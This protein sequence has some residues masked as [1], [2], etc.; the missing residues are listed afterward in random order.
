MKTNKEKYDSYLGIINDYYA[1]R[2]RGMFPSGFPVQIYRINEKYEIVPVAIKETRFS[3]G[4]YSKEK[5]TR[6]D[7]A[8]IKATSEN[9]GTLTPEQVLFEYQEKR[10]L[11][12]ALGAYRMS[13]VLKKESVAFSPDEN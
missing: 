5:P 2:L 3:V 1:S 7:V 9:L 12:T 4:V 11:F 10:G 13:E 8:K 6:E